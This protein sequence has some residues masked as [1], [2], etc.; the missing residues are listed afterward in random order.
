[1]GK[2]KQVSKSS[3]P[4]A[5]EIAAS[6]GKAQEDNHGAPD[7]VFK[8]MRVVASTFVLISNVFSIA[9]MVLSFLRR[10]EKYA[11]TCSLNTGD[12]NKWTFGQT[13]AV[14]LLV[15]VVFTGIDA[16]AGK[17]APSVQRYAEH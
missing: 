3:E 8:E 2:K 12:E 9:A 14:V 7:H 5:V 17:P 11:T 15:G 16:H 6:N 13:V 1:M 10:R 4:S